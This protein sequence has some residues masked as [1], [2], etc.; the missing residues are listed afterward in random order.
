ML[1]PRLR[2]DL[3]AQ[4]GRAIC[5][6]LSVEESSE[7][8]SDRDLMGSQLGCFLSVGVSDRPFDEL[9]SED[10]L[11]QASHQRHQKS[12]PNSPLRLRAEDARVCPY[13]RGREPTAWR[14]RW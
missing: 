8:P 2:D 5:S 1:S 14:S 3:R 4:L 10:F 12:T 7:G 11:V 13:C 9:S 6:E